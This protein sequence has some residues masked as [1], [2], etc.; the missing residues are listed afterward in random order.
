MRVS[1][2][3]AISTSCSSTKPACNMP[4]MSAS[5]IAP[6][7]IHATVFFMLSIHLEVAVRRVLRRRR[8]VDAD[9]AWSKQKQR[10]TE[11]VHATVEGVSRAADEVDQSPGHLFRDEFDG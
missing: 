4:P 11:A 9:V 10:L 1:S 8:H 7:P 2:A 6:T 3:S 5:P